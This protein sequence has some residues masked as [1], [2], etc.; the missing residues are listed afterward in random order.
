MQTFSFV[1]HLSINKRHTS[2]N[3]NSLFSALIN[4]S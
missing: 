2:V 3:I 1:N 4:E